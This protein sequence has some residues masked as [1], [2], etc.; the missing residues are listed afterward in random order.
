MSAAT[1][2]EFKDKQSFRNFITK[3]KYVVILFSATYCESSKKMIPVFINISKDHPEVKFVKI[4]IDK[5]G[6]IAQVY[7]VT[8][9]PTFKF[10][11]SS[12]VVD[13]CFD[14]VGIELNN[15]VVEFN[16]QAKGNM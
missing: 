14:D 6:E 16:E 9:T 11:R 8:D 15:M 1:V 10:L 13:E 4:D 2:H 12:E 5:L 7:G 3:N